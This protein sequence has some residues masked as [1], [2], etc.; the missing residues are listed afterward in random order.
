MTR[1]ISK[2]VEL[3]GDP[4]DITPDRWDYV[5]N[6]IAG[7][8]APAAD[9]PIIVGDLKR[10]LLTSGNEA[11]KPLR[12]ICSIVRHLLPT[13]WLETPNSRL[14]RVWCFTPRAQPLGRQARYIKRPTWNGQQLQ[15]YEGPPGSPIVQKLGLWTRCRA[16][17][18][19]M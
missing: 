7:R 4:T 9:L 10:L 16:R 3:F 11:E 1:L 2:S 15:L 17:S 8:S 5:R 13:R 18:P 12:D 6:S 19:R 14:P